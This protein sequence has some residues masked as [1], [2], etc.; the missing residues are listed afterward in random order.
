MTGIP[1]GPDEMVEEFLLLYQFTA[2]RQRKKGLLRCA[3]MKISRFSAAT[4]D[5]QVNLSGAKVTVDNESSE[6]RSRT[7]GPRHRRRL[8]GSSRPSRSKVPCHPKLQLSFSN[9]VLR[10]INPHSGTGVGIHFISLTLSSRFV[11]LASPDES[12]KRHKET[13]WTSVFRSFEVSS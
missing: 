1:M 13:V 6:R 12:D 3:F 9:P 11:A 5:A 10:S 2:T 8:Q 4:P 7:F